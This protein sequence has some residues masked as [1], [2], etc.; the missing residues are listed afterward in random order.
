MGWEGMAS[1]FGERTSYGEFWWASRLYL[2]GW[3]WS[4]E[5][6]HLM[7]IRWNRGFV[8]TVMEVPA[9]PKLLLKSA[10]VRRCESRSVCACLCFYH[11]RIP[12][13]NRKLQVVKHFTVFCPSY[14]FKKKY[15]NRIFFN[16]RD[17][18]EH[19]SNH[20]PQ[21][22]TLLSLHRTTFSEGGLFLRGY[23]LNREVGHLGGTPCS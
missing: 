23:F 1:I 5:G 13:R 4:Y 6:F 21:M 12:M 18:E 19:F 17:N 16:M 7:D 22:S 20:A 14:K 10:A 11:Y 9:D 3:L 2:G 8:M 15:L